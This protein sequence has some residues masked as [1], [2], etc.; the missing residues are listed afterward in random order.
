MREA[1]TKILANWRSETVQQLCDGL[2]L[3]LDNA[4]ET[5]VDFAAKTESVDLQTT[6]FDAQ[7][8]LAMQGDRVL[9]SFR[10]ELEQSESDTLAK[11]PAP[12]DE[13]L[14]LLER[15]AYERSVALDTIANNCILRNQQ[16]FHALKQRISAI[17]GGRKFSV[18]ALPLNPKRVAGSFETAIDLLDISSKARLV[19]FTLFDRYVMNR[20]DIALSEINRQL[21]EA[22]VLPTVKYTVRKQ[23]SSGT[24]TA[25]AKTAASP[26]EDGADSRPEAARPGEPAS[27]APV[28]E[29]APSAEQTMQDITQLVAAQR[30]RERY[31]ELSETGGTAPPPI[32]PQE[33]R[34]RALEALNSPQIVQQAPNVATQ[35]LTTH[36]N[37]I[38][39][40]KDLLLRVRS[41]LKKQRALINSLMG[42]SKNVGDREQ[43]AIDIVGML[44]EAM[45]DDQTLPAQLK[46]LLSHLHTPYLKIAVRDPKCLT[47]T[48]HPARKILGYMLQLGM[49]WVDP[50][51]L[52]SG[53]YPTL[54]YCVRKIIDS[55][56]NVDYHELE[57]ELARKAAQLEQSRKV[58]EKRTLEA[59][60]GKTM[61]ARARETAESATKAL[62][63]THGLPAEV[64][65]F[66]QTVFT[67]Y[68][69]LQLLRNDLNPNHPSCKESLGAAVRLIE[70][71]EAED[72]ASAIAAG[73]KLRNLIVMLLP[74]YQDKIDL[75]VSNLDTTISHAEREQA[76]ASK[77]EAPAA[78]KKVS[79]VD[80]AA[81]ARVLQIPVGSWFMLQEAPADQPLMVKLL[82]ANPHT[83]HVLFVDQHGQKRARLTL[84]EVASDL[85]EGIL[86]PIDLKPEGVFGRLLQ[87]IKQRLESTLATGTHS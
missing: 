87:N 43:N 62:L 10:D 32:P 51:R 14:S 15:D 72:T 35:L 77:P 37:K 69:S 2:N 49:R 79:E 46:A 26:A 48:N 8:L 24:G 60:K 30:R 12:G 55:P 39:I 3:L 17:Y 36:D 58:S 74:H 16:N 67:D 85:D 53:I 21:A 57:G 78:E 18:N 59:E 25:Q 9:A 1:A 13:T 76:E 23:G 66:L 75:F 5:L 54:Q 44:F 27:G 56:E 45:L 29:S 47:D 11:K 41:T 70:S 65:S 81:S 80:E 61:L 33:S 34:R 38:V 71:V 28:D 50:E 20:L 52:R 68:M 84:E 82:W 31:K 6:F 22:G 73:D 40:D 83:R 86:K 63:Q 7:H 64:R 19:L 42:G 4:G